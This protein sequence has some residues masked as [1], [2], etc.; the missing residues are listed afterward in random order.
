MKFIKLTTKHNSTELGDIFNKLNPIE[1]EYITNLYNKFDY[2]EFN[3]DNDNVCMFASIH[4]NYI[5]DL[6]E[7][8]VKL[9]LNFKYEDIT[10]DVLYSKLDFKIFE[11]EDLTKMIDNFIK[12]NLDV[13]TV[14]D[15]INEFGRD[16]LVEIDMLVLTRF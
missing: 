1:V 11:S 13:D 4:T 3:D 10:K 12:E 6:L 5:S 16:S 2:F 14:L 7:S 15:K 8:Y 9:S